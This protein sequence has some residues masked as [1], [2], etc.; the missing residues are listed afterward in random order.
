MISDDNNAYN[1]SMDVKAKQRPCYQTGLVV[2]KL[3]TFG[4]APRH[5]SSYQLSVDYDY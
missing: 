1:N 4:F 3:C 5:L 2:L